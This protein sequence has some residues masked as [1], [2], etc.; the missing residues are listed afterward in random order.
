MGVG[1]GA[2]LHFLSGPNDGKLHAASASLRL[3]FNP[4]GFGF[5][6]GRT[7]ALPSLGSPPPPGT[8]AWKLQ[9]LLCPGAGG[10]ARH[11]RPLQVPGISAAGRSGTLKVEPA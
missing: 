4:G 6:S 1:E 10:T 11:Q 9:R 8:K 7:R 5:L 3:F 2:C